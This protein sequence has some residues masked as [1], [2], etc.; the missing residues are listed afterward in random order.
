MLL[1]G[2]PVA[3]PLDAALVP[4]SI[5]PLAPLTVVP[6]VDTTSPATAAS[7]STLLARADQ[8]L[9]Y[10]T[11]TVPLKTPASGD[12][13]APVVAQ[14]TPAESLALP[15]N[16]GTAGGELMSL[17]WALMSASG[18][19]VGSASAAIM[20]NAATTAGDSSD[21]SSPSALLATPPRLASPSSTADSL[22]DSTTS[23]SAPEPTQ[24]P[25]ANDTTT[26]PLPADTARPPATVPASASAS[27][28]LASRPLVLTEWI[29]IPADLSTG[30]WSTAQ[31]GGTAGQEGTVT[32]GGGDAVLHEGDSFLVALTRQD[33][34][35][36]E[37]MLALTFTYTD[38]H[39][40]TTDPSFIN[41][42]FEVALVDGDG[43]SLVDTISPSRDVF[44]NITEDIPAAL[45]AG[46][47]TATTAEG[48][49]V[50]VD[51]T[52]VPAGSQA[53][54]IFRLV[55]NDS[56]QQ[57]SVRILGY[58]LLGDQTEPP[59][60]SLDLAHDT[61]PEGPGTDAYRSDRITNDST[62]TGTASDD[63]GVTKLEIKVDGG[64]WV[65]ITST[66]ENGSFSYNPGPLT[67]GL[68]EVMVRATDGEEQ[69]TL[70]VTSFTVNQLPVANA[71]GN[72]TV[73]EGSTVQFDASG[74]TDDYPLYAWSWMLDD[75]STVVGP[76][77]SRHYPQNGS[78]PVSLT[79][80]DIAGSTDTDLVE[81]QVDNLAAVIRT[82]TAPAKRE[83]QQLVF[84]ATFEDAGVLDTH[85]AKVLWSDGT[86]SKGIVVESGGTG[87][88]R[89]THTYGDNG[90]YPVRLTL[91]DSDGAFSSRRVNA[92][93]TNVAPT[94]TASRSIELPTA[95]EGHA[96]GAVV[97]SGSFTD[98]GFN[99]P[100]AKTK[101]S[102]AVTIDWG[103]GSVDVF[104]PTVVQ[105]TAGRVTRGTFSNIRHVYSTGGVF[106]TTVRVTDDDGGS[107][108]IE[109]VYA[110]GRVD[111]K[112]AVRDPLWQPN[113]RDDDKD[114][115]LPHGLIPVVLFSDP[116]LDTTQLSVS[117]LR[118]NPGDAPEYD[119]NL[120]LF[121]IA[122]R[123]GRVD[124]AAHFSTWAVDL[125]PE[126][127][128]GIIT[129]RLA[130]GTEYWGWD[131]I[132]V[133]PP[134]ERLPDA[135][136]PPGLEPSQPTKF[137]VVD[138]A[139][140][141]TF[142]YTAAG[143]DNGKFNIAGTARDPRGVT[144]NLTGS[145]IWVIDR[146]TKKVS[147]YKPAGELLGSW[148]PRT[149]RT[150]EGIATDGSG[151]WIV[152]SAADAVL[153]YAGAAARRSG[154]LSPASSFKLHAENTSP[155][156]LVTDGQRIWVTD[157]GTDEVFLYSLTGQ[158]QGRW[159]L[160]RSNSDPSG[161]TL[162]PA[163]GTDLWVVD[164]VDR[165]VYHYAAGT[166][167]TAGTAQASDT[168]LLAAAN[169]SPEGIADPPVQTPEGDSLL[170]QAGQAVYTTS[171]DFL[172]GRLFNV[173]A[174]EVPDELRLNPAGEIQT[175]PFI[176]I[177][178]SGEGTLSRFD[179][180]TGVEIG[181]YRTG[182]DAA[183]DPSRICVTP[184][185]DAWVANRGDDA[186]L[187]G[188][189]VKVLREGFV[190]RNGNGVVDTC[191][192]LDGDGY[193]TGSEILPWDAN[194]DGQPDDERI[195]M[196]I[197]AGRSRT[198]TAT[199]TYGGGAR[200]IAVD[201][202]G[203]LWVGL[204]NR[205][206]Y[207]V[208]DEAT[209]EFETVVP[210]SG[211][212]YGAVIAPN[213]ILY[214]T[215]SAYR[216]LDAI[217]TGTQQYLAK[218]DVQSRMYG[219]TVDPR[220]VVWLSPHQATNLIRYDTNTGEV[221]LYPAPPNTDSGGGIA[222]D[223][224]GSVWAGMYS[225]KTSGMLKWDFAA[226]GKTLTGSQI[227]SIPGA[228]SAKSASIDADGYV[229]TVALNANKAF[230]L[231]PDTNS[232]VMSRNTGAGPYNYSDMTGSI[233]IGSTE[234]TGSWTEIIDSQENGRPWGT[235]DLDAVLP[236]GSY[237]RL[238][239]RASDAREALNATAWME[240]QPGAPLDSLRGRYLE[241]EVTLRSATAEATP[242]VANITVAAI[243]AP[244]ITVSSPADG[245][246]LVPGQKIVISGKA[247]AA[248]QVGPAPTVVPNRITAVLVNGTAA[249]VVDA[250]GN[251]FA[252]VEILPGRNTFDI[253][254]L[255]A[256]GQSAGTT[257]TLTGDTDAAGSVDLL[258]DV[259]PSFAAEYARTSFDERTGLL[260]AQTAI[261]N[262]GDYEA[263]NPFYVGIRNISDPTVT[264]RNTAGRT[265]DGIPYY[266]FSPVV[267]G[268]SLTAGEITGFVD[269]V[270]H[271]PNRVPFN[272][273]L[274][275]LA[276]LNEPPRFTSVPIVETYGGRTY[277][278]NADATD[279]DEDPLT[280]RLVT[281]PGGMTIDATSGQITWLATKDDLGVHDVAIRV[282]DGRGGAAEQRYLL[283]V[284]DLPPNRP[285]LITS[286][287]VTE[288]FLGQASLPESRF[289][290]GQIFLASS[291]T[292][293]IRVYDAE[294]L[295]FIRSFSH[296]LL[297]DTEATY[298]FSEG[299]NGTAFNERGN[300]VV[301][302][303]THFVEFSDYGVEYARYPKIA[304]ESTENII[305]D[306]YG[307]LYTTTSTFGS[308]QL[309]QY[310]AGDY[311]FRQ[312][313]PLPPGAGQLTGIVFDA[314]GR[315]YVGSQL[316]RRIHVLQA[317][318]TYSSFAYL[319]AFAAPTGGVGGVE[320]LQIN[321][322]GELV[323][324]GGD[325]VRY[326][327]TT[328]EIL[329]QFDAPNNAAPVPLAIDSTGRIYTADWE[330]GVGSHS[331]DLSRFSPDGSSFISINDPG[332][333][334]PFGMAVSGTVLPGSHWATY[335]YD[336]DATDPDFDPV[337][338]SLMQSPTGMNIDP[339][340]GLITWTPSEDQLGD[341]TVSVQASDGR[342]GVDQQMF[343]VRVNSQPGNHPP[344]IVSEPV[345]TVT[346]SED[347]ELISNGD[348]SSGNVGFSSEYI[349]LASGIGSW[350][351]QYGVGHRPSDFLPGTWSDFGD[352]TS[353]DG[354][355][356]IVN[357]STDASKYLWSQTV[358]T[359]PDG[360]YQITARAASV[361]HDNRASLRFT[362]NGV[363]VG[364]SLALGTPGQWQTFTATWHSGNA[365]SATISV[366][367]SGTAFYGNDFALDDI[368]FQRLAIDYTYDVDALDSDGDTLTYSLVT[369]PATM[370][371]DSASGLISWQP[372]EGDIGSHPVTVRASDGRGEFDL[373]TFTIDVLAAGSGEIRG[374]KFN[375]LDGDGI[376]ASGPTF[377][378]ASGFSATANP[379]GNWVSGWE[380]KNSLGAGFTPYTQAW[381]PNPLDYWTVAP[382]QNP[383]IAYNGTSQTYTD[384][385]QIT[386]QPGQIVL[387]P[388]PS[389]EY[390]LDRF[391]IPVASIYSID[392]V[393][394][395]LDAQHG[396]TDVHVL[397]N[398]TSIY[399]AQVVVD[400]Q[401]F[402][403]GWLT[404][405][406][407]DTVDFAVGYGANGS[408]SDD[409][410]GLYATITAQP[411]PGLPNWTIYLDQNQN[412]RRDAGER[413]TITDANGDYAF[414]GLPAGTYYVAEESRSGW[415]Q[416][417]PTET[418]AGESIL[419]NGSFEQGLSTGS[420][421]TLGAGSTAMPGWEVTQA[422]VDLVHKN[423]FISSDGNYSVDLT[424]SP[425]AGGLVQQLATIPGQS[426]LVA[427]DVA[428]NP[429]GAPAVKRVRVEAAGT[430]AEYTYDTTGL[431]PST[432]LWRREEF[433]FTANS[434][435][436]GLR[437]TS[438][439]DD[440]YGP[441]IDNLRVTPLAAASYHRVVLGDKV[442]ATGKDFGNQP[443]SG[444][445]QPPAF[446]SDP[447][448]SASS[449][450]L[451]RYDSV[452][453]D[454][455]NDSLTF[456]LPLAPDGMTVHPD[457]G[458]VVWQPTRDQIGT[459]QVVLRVKDGQGGIDLQ[460][461][462]V[463]VAKPNSAPVFTSIPPDTAVVEYPLVYLVHAQ[464][465][466]A[467]DK[468][469]FRL[470]NPLPGMAIDE[471][472]GKFTWTPT[473]GQVGPQSI[474]IVAFDGHPGGETRQTFSIN[475]VASAPNAPP[476][477][478]STP[479]LRARV[480]Q[481]Y[482]Y[483]VLAS[484]PNGDALQYSLDTAPAGMTLDADG[485]LH[486]VPPS[487][488]LGTSQ[489][490]TVRVDDG[491][492]GFDT[493]SFAIEVVSQD[494]N[495]A[496]VVVSTPLLIAIVGRTYQYD[497]AAEDPEG[498]PVV[499]SLDQAPAGMS[500]DPLRGTVRW[501]P[502]ADQAGPAAVVVR[503][504]D[505][506]LAANTQSFTI[507]VRA[508]NAPPA[509]LS[510]PPV[511]ANPGE[512]YVY[513]LRASD[514]DRDPLSYRLSVKPDGMTIDPATGLVRWTPTAA[515][516]GTHTVRVVVED[517]QGGIDSQS[518]LL[519]V[520]QQAINRPPLITSQPGYR[521]G[522]GRLYQYAV[523]ASDPEGRPVTFSLQTNPNG[524]EIDTATGLI[525]WTPTPAQETDHTVTVVATD[526]MNA[527][528]VQ[529]Y[530]LT[531]RPNQAPQFRLPG[532]Q[533]AAASTVYRYD[534]RAT[535]PEGDAVTYS[536][537]SGPAGM[538][539]D[540]G[541]IS[542]PTTL[543]DIPTSPHQ[544]S[545]VA[546]DSFGAAT[547]LTFSIAVLADTLA[548]QVTLAAS[549][550]LADLNGEV[551]FYVQATDNVGVET[552][553][554][555]VGGTAVAL[556]A[557]GRAT[558]RMSQPGLIDAVAT[559]TDASGNTGTS[560]AWQVRV[561]DPSD[562]QHPVVT[563]NALIP[564]VRD[565][566]TGGLKDGSRI[567]GDALLQSPVLNYLTDVEVSITDDNMGDW[568]IEYA[569]T[570]AVN[571]ANLAAND[572]DYVLL[573]EGV[574]V[575][576][577]QRF[578][579]DTTLLANDAYVLRVSAYDIN[580]QG[581]VEP[582]M[583][584]VSSN[585]KLGNFTF[586]LTDFSVSLA[587]IP[588]QVARTYDTLQAGTEGDFGYGW[589][590]AIS[591]ANIAETTRAGTE[592]QPGDRVYLTNPEG[593]RIGFT[594][595]PTYTSAW[596]FG[597]IANPAFKADPGVSEK[598]TVKEGS[599]GAGG[600]VGALEG[601][602][603]NPSQY[604]LTTKDGSVYEY[605]QEQGLQKITDR[606]GNVVTFTDTAITHSAGAKIDLVR[607][608][609][610]RIKE[611]V[612]TAGN[613]IRYTYDAAGNLATFSNQIDVQSGTPTFTYGYRSDPAHFLDTI[614]D[615]AGV[616][617]FK[618]DF[619]DAGRLT[620]STD[621][622]GN[623]VQQDFDPAAFSGTITDA[624]GNVTTL[625][626]D[627]QGNVTKEQSAPVINPITGLAVTYEKTYEYADPRH[628]DKETKIVEYDGTI[629][630]HQYDAA[631]NTIKTTRTGADGSRSTTTSFKYDTS[632]NLTQVEMPG[633]G[634]SIFGYAGGNATSVTSALGNVAYATYNTEG[635][636]ETFTD[637]NGNTT[638]YEYKDG[639]PC[640]T[641]KK[642]KY[643]DGSF[644]LREWNR[645]ALVTKVE[646]YEANGTLAHVTTTDY[647]S[648]GR[649]TK[650]T[651]GASLDQVVTTY[652]YDGS[653]E[654]VTRQ[655]VV[656]PSDPSKSRVTHYFYDNAG[657]LARQVDP[658]LDPSDPTA[659]IFF[660]YDASGNRV[661]LR[662]PV[663]NVT[664]WVY[665]ALNRVIEE[666]DPLYWEGTDWA[667]MT[668][669]EI[670]ALIVTPTPAEAAPYAASHIIRYAYDGAGNLVEKV[671]RNG[672]R[673]TFD[674]DHQENLLQ[675]VW[676][677][678]ADDV[679]PLRAL[680]FSYDAAGNML[681]ATDPDAEY[682]FT[683]DTMNRLKTMSVDYPWAAN[684]DTFTLT[685]SYD[686]MGNV[687]STTD[688][689]GVA[690][691]STYDN[692]NRLDSRWWEGSQID[693]IR[694][695]FDYTAVG[696][697][698][699]VDRWADKAQT[700]R[701]G[702]S[703][704]VHDLAGRPREILH[705][706]AA[707]E[708]LAG[709]DYEFDFAGLLTKEVLDHIT[710]SYDRTATYGYDFRGQLIFA[711]YDNDQPDEAFSYDANGNRTM[712]G[713]V[714][715]PGNQLLSDGAYRY[716]YDAEGNMVTKTRIAT[717]AGEV[718]YTEFEYDFCNR[719]TKVTQYSK[720][721][722]EGGIIL[723][724][725]SYRYD[726]LGRRIH[727]ASDGEE[728]ISVY[729]GLGFVDNE[730]A[731]YGATGDLVQRF[732]F[733]DKVDR[734]IAEWT[735]GQA[736]TWALTDHLGTI[737][738]IIT[739]E[740][741]IQHIRYSGYGTPMFSPAT[742]NTHP[743]AFT[744]R[745]WDNIPGLSFHRSRIY[746]PRIGRFFSFDPLKF[747]SGESN[748][749]RY[750][751]NHPVL[752]SDPTGALALWEYSLVSATIST[753]VTA[754]FTR[755]P[756][757]LAEG[758]F[759]GLG[760]GLVLNYFAIS[761]A[762]EG[763]IVSGLVSG[764]T[765]NIG[766]AIL[767][768]E[769]WQRIADEWNRLGYDWIPF[770]V[771]KSFL[772]SV[773]R[774]VVTG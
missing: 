316:D 323:A 426:Y 259:S 165:L 716:T 58:G 320:G 483:Q 61:A 575:I 93:I 773:F 205:R 95:A 582:L 233:R 319:T 235:V 245:S 662:D 286:L 295:Q 570:S 69:S 471:N 149:V 661:W 229:W 488:L 518:Y 741:I 548:P 627:E 411:E 634:I 522:T 660:K 249:D 722:S 403:S 57:T 537:T 103:D 490:V 353:G 348:F 188:N 34:E 262:V 12:E 210:V 270:F 635:K 143:A 185:G 147:V 596:V 638:L 732:L 549:T 344:V 652:V 457:R 399:D 585:A 709:Y 218:I 127:K 698:K 447:P 243:P 676:Y 272:Y 702:S 545:V 642:V 595:E 509:I 199:W 181:R 230:K 134:S 379:N 88:V 745:V 110:L 238:R 280:Y 408:H 414:T 563:I 338:Y 465:A 424:G 531:V 308:S 184:D 420:V 610:G 317:D 665:D 114:T 333:F 187:W 109:F 27:P 330:N 594:Y 675:E 390:A 318:P 526:D 200:G 454:P 313:I 735:K 502:A 203:K 236:E 312:T 681:T 70:A 100:K 763:A 757:K 512:L 373:Q 65:D 142:R 664:T 146:T 366:F 731:R 678:A 123:D 418:I 84:R 689:T 695:D 636:Q 470:E 51:L 190:D 154:A 107:D 74:S 748:L 247:I 398:G 376:R 144:S 221:N 428:G 679:T 382:W 691:K 569:P 41:D 374:T 442:V 559:A 266:N 591:D 112:P 10:T 728:T 352:H 159:K 739:Q 375:D 770:P 578:R 48:E 169:V 649:K 254:A 448:A 497:M 684:F 466:D 755:D 708:V 614:R 45:G 372:G 641:P 26:T 425:G 743:F 377:T 733:T 256:Y 99:Q 22:T 89:A 102:F 339:A 646:Y 463:T 654:K 364:T 633:G 687:V 166:L 467:A 534:L 670:L 43:Y 496:P 261:R 725:E 402:S 240:I 600:I 290:S 564:Q 212:P 656:H 24:T 628:P 615:H 472:S 194:G 25:A 517:D 7:S 525:T 612:D 404:L 724:E 260:Y 444:A 87:T 328:G 388:G 455:D 446:T 128:T 726:A 542:W 486:W 668:D 699:H 23:P 279:A 289:Q 331:A 462:T 141:S 580:G 202:H 337:S 244:A 693:N 2:G 113:C 401:H 524:M 476:E 180:R 301:A 397:V 479:R 124:A 754:V 217:D 282:A 528:A 239:V 384:G 493:Q 607:D 560:S 111:I 345:T 555:T 501:T 288:A 613:S 432:L 439:V 56:D 539:I 592:M 671:D 378:A 759:I 616:R 589:S 618:A 715:G 452:A 121:D 530:V 281:A 277:S 54:L 358:T 264:L 170:D 440:Y 135:I 30:G 489:A 551:V 158:F 535:D 381:H 133:M 429:Y 326:N 450:Q 503:V 451:L 430:S 588:I 35:I 116:T 322:N 349:Y 749:Y 182:A 449:D 104:A 304:A 541:R 371:I 738:D 723:H 515:Q 329:G 204:Q 756:K 1:P 201:T 536:L 55:N 468:P 86:T 208:F 473:T 744:A 547:P 421:L 150:P 314:E 50:T 5:A 183:V 606:N 492:G 581:W 186:T 19:S 131:E 136:W 46:V 427:F 437:F 300:L 343:V 417:Y 365:T 293:E 241:T 252:Q 640:G 351:T 620:G 590:M 106:Q 198:N 713:Y 464:D 574:G 64:E 511:Q 647:D 747:E 460:S 174:T 572:P 657:R 587:G 211:N 276:R 44:F 172:T 431:S 682:V 474:T 459:H 269:A 697:L 513:A 83:G 740:G 593:R 360:V 355:M 692:R 500:I 68:R 703:N 651:I 406:A 416:T 274:V 234:R 63:L 619:D 762:L 155:S 340:S 573:A 422:T 516:N 391:T 624:R 53:T 622:L 20:S 336:V 197:H 59:Q 480:G 519:N 148:L 47:T 77:A 76:A 226:D 145:K 527:R 438:L 122:P 167:L 362:I 49:T 505:V 710:D 750:V 700:T 60:V 565:E 206:Q 680:V 258:F 171:E 28:Q 764:T 508:V 250:D 215:T 766:N 354:L 342:G 341:N 307:N 554:L 736:L 550:N 257:L 370:S 67:P 742:G 228:S 350:D 189:A 639:C 632:N 644:E 306:S 118:F 598:L 557:Q 752:G 461:F 393:F 227:V 495:T 71:G 686:A 90:V 125:G 719:M 73:T 284:T 771:V 302:G 458:I 663:G 765:N 523:K 477:I 707:D 303:F 507:N 407:G 327:R 278:Y 711:L 603:W 152:D 140:D 690:V 746:D 475:V 412:G 298:A 8:S 491:R 139:A 163:G 419:V 367:D 487:E 192:D 561:F 273:E 683:Y 242:S 409:A 162:N 552:L 608:P 705:K 311:S 42:A 297:H 6:T 178:N 562:Q 33:L 650:E 40:D 637:F 433:V 443:I 571:T 175:Y 706:N 701:V 714:T 324:A 191:Q 629:V 543:A 469:K 361:F 621:A 176:W 219:I 583:F 760:V 11:S 601:G 39:F 253:T 655:T 81:V 80:T 66:L 179:T 309:N 334:G 396:G 405:A 18:G 16:S 151:I 445:N 506:F 92:R 567:E 658:D 248:T 9:S 653:T 31:S 694:A 717:V 3:T 482:A 132:P 521:A 17:E 400:P 566:T 153:Y 173:N 718:N 772:L 623:V 98:P 161:I 137:F 630:E 730:W 357:G 335:H 672:R 129:G 727:V 29:D 120:K 481:S 291:V 677:D 105:G 271:N 484:D 126:D 101:E 485:V 38:L 385:N 14:D 225:P 285:P 216:Y 263:D 292:D 52:S 72:R 195:A 737:R 648:R 196:V 207:E 394:S 645:Q 119:Q 37:G 4:K 436:T 604:V 767:P 553:S 296:P 685:Y 386:V 734:L 434:N 97:I 287:P 356:M 62:V 325:L 220:G 383:L 659:G 617:I 369:S 332:L 36:E 32:P 251:F 625:W 78:Y 315:L 413:F 721:P 720:A 265:K 115:S 368:S 514:P 138:A 556:D 532:P 643:P 168:F 224:N 94:L 696:Q 768:P 751:W 223:R 478:T 688:S 363:T 626:Y 584:G 758:F 441:L 387:H 712:A 237:L 510:T 222:V 380:S 305:F 558:V 769:L 520:G 415:T 674:Y 540:Q 494:T 667:S 268:E 538:T 579:I 347:A 157:E 193:I 91:A 389:G 213:G 774:K 435:V 669:V 75:G 533:S 729:E 177:A 609:R 231:D 753:L 117:S 599:Y 160:D 499:W 576:D 246:T 299:P 275:F 602:N 504:R 156:D 255:D 321:I 395:S 586:T 673:R 164:R 611:I 214:S 423:H 577:H 108:S 597:I 209:G 85:T 15:A 546:T 666:R 392:A 82:I 96:V 359:S 267:P 346:I 605:V 310:R 21:A 631:G 704:Y 568:R 283:S 544:V 294:T 410:T 453:I 232:V 456:D 130:D 498:D 529:T 13:A 761:L 79:V